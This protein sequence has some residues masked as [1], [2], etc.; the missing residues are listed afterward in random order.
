MAFEDDGQKGIEFRS[1]LAVAFRGV[2]RCE[3]ERLRVWSKQESVDRTMIS[4][5]SVA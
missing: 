1:W 3:L 2:R 4:E 5:Q